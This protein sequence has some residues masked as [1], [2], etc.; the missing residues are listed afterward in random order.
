MFTYDVAQPTDQMLL[1]EIL[2]LDNGEPLVV[3]AFL[4]RTP[5]FCVRSVTSV[6]TVSQP[7]IRP[8]NQIQL[9]DM[10]GLGCAWARFR[11][12]T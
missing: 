7:R 3:D 12:S 8:T 2:D 9:E 10:M 6:F 11:C 4:R 1:D 5:L